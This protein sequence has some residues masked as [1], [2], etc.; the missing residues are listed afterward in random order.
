MSA[1]VEAD[2]ETIQKINEQQANNPAPLP[3]ADVV[4]YR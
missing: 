1:N 3:D 2:T 4:A